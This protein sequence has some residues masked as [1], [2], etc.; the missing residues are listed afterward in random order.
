MLLSTP[1]GGRSSLRDACKGAARKG[2]QRTDRF[3]P[4]IA[5]VPTARRSVDRRRSPQRRTGRGQILK[6]RRVPKVENDVCV[7]TAYYVVVGGSGYPY[8]SRAAAY[9]PRL[10]QRANSMAQWFGS[11]IRDISRQNQ[12]SGDRSA[13]TRAHNVWPRAPPDTRFKVL[14]RLPKIVIDASRELQTT[15][16]LD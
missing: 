10:C 4:L 15:R 13:A 6:R 11:T 9:V 16:G 2:R 14:E 1:K 8:G 12:H 3:A 5:P 7:A